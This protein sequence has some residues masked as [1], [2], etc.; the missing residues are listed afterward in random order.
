MKLIKTTVR[1]TRVEDVRNALVSLNIAEM[2]VTE[3]R[4][5]RPSPSRALSGA[6]PVAPSAPDA[7]IELIVPDE[8]VAEVIQTLT[9][10]ARSEAIGDGHI[11]VIPLDFA[12]NIQISAR[13]P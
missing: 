3:V 13:W 7:L 12:G 1:G 11:S 9:R 4:G 5:H 10:A 2:T 6:G 8:I